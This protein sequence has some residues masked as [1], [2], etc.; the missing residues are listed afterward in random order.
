MRRST[1]PGSGEG[2]TGCPPSPRVCCFTVTLTMEDKPRAS[3]CPE[4]LAAD[5]GQSFISSW[6]VPSPTHVHTQSFILHPRASAGIIVAHTCMHT[7]THTYMQSSTLTRR[8]I[9]PI[10]SCAHA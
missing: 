5:L 9:G 1:S 6:G 10:P 2:V 4:V 7:M 3:V 8:H